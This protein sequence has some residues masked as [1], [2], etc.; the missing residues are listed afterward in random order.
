[1]SISLTGS[2]IDVSGGSLASLSELL[3]RVAPDARQSVAR[4]AD[5]PLRTAAALVAEV[6]DYVRVVEAA[7]AKDAFIDA[8]VAAAL[9]GASVELATRCEAGAAE[10][11]LLAQVAIRYFI[12]EDDAE[13]DLSSVVGFDDDAEVMNAVVELLGMDDLRIDIQ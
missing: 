2:V 6:R 5:E 7:A 10:D 11:R 9:A 12:L 1:M 8:K 13:G 4:L 3:E